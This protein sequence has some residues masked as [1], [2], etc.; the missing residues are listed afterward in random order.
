M[1]VCNGASTANDI[2]WTE[3]I[4]VVPNTNYNFSAWVA[5]TENTNAAS[6]AQLQFSIN[7]ALI[8]PIYT[9]P[10]TGG[11][12]SNFFVNWNSGLNNTAV[13]TI[14]DQNTA[15]G[16]NDFALDDIFYQQVCSFSDTLIITE[17]PIPTVTASASNS[18]ICNG[19][20]TTLTASGANTYT[21]TSGVTN[22]A[23]FTPTTTATY[24]VIGTSAA[25]CTN[26]AVTT[27]TVN[28]TPTLSVNNP[29]IC[30]G[31]TAT[32]TA[33]GANTYT[34]SN[35]AIGNSQSVNPL[36]TTT[37]S[38]SGTDLNG[39]TTTIVTTSTV[40]VSATPTI[41]INSATICAGQTTTLTAIGA[42]NYTWSTTETMASINATPVLTTTYSVLGD[43]G[44]CSSIA[45]TTVNVTPIPTV[46]ASSNLSNGCAPFCT[47]F[48]DI[49]S[50][51]AT[52]IIYNFGDGSTSN[53]NN[54]NH[55]YS[56]TGSYTVTATVT[57]SILG[58]SSTFTLPIININISPIADF[59]I[60]EGN[61]VNVNAEL[62][63]INSSSNADN[64]LW[65]VL[66]IG[67]TSTSID[68][69]KSISDTG[70][71]CVKLIAYTINGCSDTITKCLNIISETSVI[72]PNVFTPNGDN[73]ND[74]F[75]INST[76]LKSLN[77]SIF[78]RWGLKITEWD[79]INGYWD[80]NTKSGI[81]PDGTY[82][83]IVTYT[84]QKGIT[85]TEKGF[86]TL[87][88]D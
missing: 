80:G 49:V 75:K 83:Y 73:K 72:I 84:D 13:I 3:T 74:I 54:P 27:I 17:N 87:F 5:S 24:S 23:N 28:S 56:N 33:S 82:F 66:C 14:L 77:C 34:W 4:T 52:N 68:I 12:W 32:L 67:E 78:N 30:F 21:W 53:V 44:G 86:L 1:M 22:G 38:V 18:V 39:C 16:G 31:Q 58:C 2:V 50:P 41:T 70:I 62:H 61:T 69:T 65:E 40:N 46:T 76:G 36:V 6:A 64:Y 35:N 85:K 88:N 71:C 20:S 57:N 19:N 25:G 42:T 55:C 79:T 7:N 45:T 11:V 63:F 9:A 37:Y 26:T 29:S 59:N 43:N 8:G 10:L 47:N 60:T 51:S 48:T 15:S 81:A